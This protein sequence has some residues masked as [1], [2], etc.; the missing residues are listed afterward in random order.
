MIFAGQEN[1]LTIFR[2]NLRKDTYQ[3]K[4]TKIPFK[5]AEIIR[6][7]VLLLLLL[8]FFVCLFV[9]FASS[10]FVLFCFFFFVCLFFF[11]FFAKLQSLGRL[12]LIS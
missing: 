11:L 8:L 9:C 1:L 4:L 7:K 3:S 10:F 12:F 6:K 5:A 2:S